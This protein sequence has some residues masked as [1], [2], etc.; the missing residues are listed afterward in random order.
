MA[1]FGFF[2]A[3]FDINMRLF[4]LIHES[5]HLIDR[6]NGR[7]ALGMPLASLNSSDGANCYD[8]KNPSQGLDFIKT[9]AYR[10]NAGGNG[11]PLAESFADA[12]ANNVFCAPGKNCNYADIYSSQNIADYPKACSNTYNWIKKNVF[13]GG[14]FFSSNT[15]AGGGTS[16]NTNDCG[17]YY[18]ATFKRSLSEPGFVHMDAPNFGDP[19]CTLPGSAQGRNA[20]YTELQRI[21]N[22]ATTKIKS[23]EEI[24]DWMLFKIVITHE[25][26]Y[27]P[28]DYSAFPSSGN[29]P[30]GLYQMNYKGKKGVRQYDVGD[31]N[32]PLQT[33][34][35]A[36][37]NT[38]HCKWRYWSTSNHFPEEIPNFGPAPRA[39]GICMPHTTVQPVK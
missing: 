7:N 16:S 36:M 25:S 4:M 18:A 39:T 21:L 32:W 37:L 27:N 24:P 34:N 3:T 12:L 2:E 6:R 19:Q 5:G 26:G 17:G 35:A 14:D 9:Y 1:I 15:A 11:G 23:G 10:G 13:D 31:V 22:G 28:N 38:E 8:T 30:Y 29:Y 20:F 33:Y